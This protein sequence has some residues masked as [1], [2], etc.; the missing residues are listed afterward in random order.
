MFG[1]KEIK[2]LDDILLTKEA[3]LKYEKMCE[4]VVDY[5]IKNGIE[6]PRKE[7]GSIDIED[8]TLSE[9]EENG[10]LVIST[11]I[12][13]SVVACSIDKGQWKYRE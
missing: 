5:M 9:I 13:Q 12:G 7:D 3:V 8:E 4:S 11:N 1:G 10:M 6:I 2:N